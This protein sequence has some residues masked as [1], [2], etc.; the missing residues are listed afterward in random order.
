[1][2][3]SYAAG[4]WCHLT[5]QCAG[6]IDPRCMVVYVSFNSIS[7]SIGLNCASAFIFWYVVLFHRATGRGPTGCQ[8]VIGERS[9]ALR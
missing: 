4:S 5:L 8:T 9:N 1:M 7:H 2:L 6:I 3:K